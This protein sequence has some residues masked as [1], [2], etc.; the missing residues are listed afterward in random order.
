MVCLGRSYHFKFFK[1]CFS[2]ILLGPFWNTLIHLIYPENK[3]C[4]K[5]VQIRS[6]FGF[7]FW[8]IRTEYFVFGHFLRSE[9]LKVNNRQKTNCTDLLDTWRKLNVQKIFVQATFWTSSECLTYV[10]FTSCFW[11]V[12]CS[13]LTLTTLEQ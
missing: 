9:I 4:V 11:Q 10:Q 5:S 13:K 7:V 6:Y 2:Q 1:V 12:M 3:H 8:P